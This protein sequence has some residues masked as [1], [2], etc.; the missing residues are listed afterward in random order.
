MRIPF[1][2]LDRKAWLRLGIAAVLVFYVMQIGFDAVKD[3]TLL[4]L[5]GDMLAF[6]SVGRIADTQGYG[7]V[8]SVDLLRQTQDSALAALG[9]DTE[10]ASTIPAPL[11]AFF[12]IPFQFLSRLAPR[13]MFWVCSAIS[14]LAIILYLMFFLRSLTGGKEQKFLSSSMLVMLMLITYPVYQNLF[15]GQVEV[16]LMICAGEFIR[17]AINKKPLLAGIWL[18]GLLIKP[19]VMILIIPALLLLRNWR[20]F[21]GFCISSVVILG[22]SIGLS[23]INGLLSMINLWLSYVP[24]IASNAPENM[25]NWRMLALHLNGWTASS[26]GWII[27]GGGML[28]T[29]IAAI[30]ILMRRPEFGTN[31]WLLA[32]FG[33]LTA[34]CAFTWHSHTHMAMI[35]IPFILFLTMRGILP[36]RLLYSWIFI[37]PLVMVLVLVAGAFMA[38]GIIP[39]VQ[40]FGGLV[41]GMCGLAFNLIF[42]VWVYRQSRQPLPSG[43]G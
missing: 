17:N 7:E 34:T 40:G 24:G 21:F 1:K 35:L 32:L 25:M 20:V 37:T 13:T 33:I 14:L 9:F 5:G 15:W 30:L 8:Y 12:L 3:N 27:A 11:F 4:G 42:T 6:W 22:I 18:G 28:L 23:G 19:Q 29:L 26:A 41:M 36:E 10:N 43:N 39:F 16:V 31:A 2:G 38:L